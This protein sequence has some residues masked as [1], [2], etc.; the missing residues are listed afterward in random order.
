MSN[1]Y[2]IAQRNKLRETEWEIKEIGHS[3]NRGNCRGDNESG[4][5]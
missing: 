3:G 2:L 4:N 5:G 1:K